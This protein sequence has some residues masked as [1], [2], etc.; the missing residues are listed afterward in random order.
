METPKLRPV[1]AFPVEIEGRQMIG[2]RD[3]LGISP[4]VLFL[5]PE[6]FFLANLMDG[7]S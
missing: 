1:E 6:A 7:T 5:S 3:P 4:E 2:L